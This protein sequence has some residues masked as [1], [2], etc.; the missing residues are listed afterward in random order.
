MISAYESD[1]REP[2]LRTLARLIEATGHRLS[3][4]LVPAPHRCLGLPDSRL[5]RRL[6]RHR[7]AVLELAEQRGAHNVRVFGSVAVAKTPTPV[8]LICW[9]TLDDGVSLIALACLGR[10]LSDLLKVRVDLVPAATLKSTVADAVL[11]E[12]VTL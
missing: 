3:I 11:A 2:G 6:R 7:R 9:S 8:A 4:D 1:R 10:Q 12:A 5:G